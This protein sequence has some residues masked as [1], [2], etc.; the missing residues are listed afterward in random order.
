M[1]VIAIPAEAK[2]GNYELEIHLEGEDGNNAEHQVA[3]FV[4]LVVDREKDDVQF[5]KAE[6]ED[7]SIKCGETTY[8]NLK[9][10]NYGSNRQDNAAVSV[11]NA[12]LNLNENY[13]DIELDQDPDDSD[14]SFSKRLPIT[15]NNQI[16]PGDYHIEVRSYLDNDEEKEFRDLKLTVER[17]TAA[18]PPTEEEEEET[19]PP[20]LEEEEETTGED[21]V[22]DNEE[23][24]AAAP[25][26]SETPLT[27][28]VV[29]QTVEDPYTSEDFFI[30]TLIVAFAV[31]VAM[32][33]VFIVMLVK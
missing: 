31:I 1:G 23:E 8:L 17:C 33:I 22:A 14:N 19:T 32:I 24:E 25:D 21:T 9:L 16:R 30:A 10:T 27:S 20:E 4:T 11:Y 2:E 26:D 28:A 7:N 3:W 12:L 15:V 13:V 18:V 29:M 5:E 6:L